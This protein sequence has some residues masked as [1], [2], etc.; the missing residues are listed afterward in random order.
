MILGIGV[1]MVAIARVRGMRERQ[2]QAFL[3][4]CFRSDEVAYCMG[5]KRVDESLAARFAA[6]E[7]VMKALG[8]G[9]AEGVSFRGIEVV[10]LP[11]GAPTVVLHG[12]AGE[13]AAALGVARIH[14]SLSHTDD[15]AIAYAVAEGEPSGPPGSVGIL[16]ATGL[17]NA[18]GTRFDE[19]RR[20]LGRGASR[21]FEEES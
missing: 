9:W 18:D 11:S 14:L 3:E 16:G 4:K 17:R 8:T 6:K 15:H 21:D 19:R 5:K 13:R 2:G 12:G 7:A 1:D 20:G 10:R